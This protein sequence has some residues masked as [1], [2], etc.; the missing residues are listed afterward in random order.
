[1]VF[2]E[3]FN[4]FIQNKLNLPAATVQLYNGRTIAYKGNLIKQAN[5][6]QN[7]IFYYQST[8]DLMQQ[9]ASQLRLSESTFR[10]SLL[11]NEALSTFLLPYYKLDC[12]SNETEQ[13]YA[14]RIFLQHAH[15]QNIFHCDPEAFN[16]ILHQAKSDFF[17]ISMS[18]E[19]KEKR[20]DW[21]LSAY[22]MLFAGLLKH[23]NMQCVSVNV[24]KLSR[25]I[26]IPD[27]SFVKHH[28]FDIICYTGDYGKR[29]ATADECKFAFIRT[30]NE[31][32]AMLT[33]SYVVDVRVYSDELPPR[34]YSKAKL[35]VN[36]TELLFEDNDGKFQ[37]VEYQTLT[38]VKMIRSKLMAVEMELRDKTVL[39]ITFLADTRQACE[40]CLALLDLNYRCR[41]NS[42]MLIEPASPNHFDPF[43]V[44]FNELNQS[45][46]STN[47]YN[48]I[49]KSSLPLG[50][51]S[52]KQAHGILRQL[53][54][55]VGWYVFFRCQRIPHLHPLC[56]VL[57]SEANGD[58]KLHRICILNRDGYFYINN[59]IS[60]KRKG[61]ESPPN[62]ANH[63]YRSIQE[64]LYSIK[65]RVCNKKLLIKPEQLVTEEMIVDLRKNMVEFENDLHK[66]GHMLSPLCLHLVPM[67][68]SRRTLSSVYT[69]Y[70]EDPQGERKDVRALLYNKIHLDKEQL[71]NI[72]RISEISRPEF[73]H[74]NILKCFGFADSFNTIYY[75]HEYFGDEILNTFHYSY[76]S[77][78][79]Y[80]LGTQLK[81]ALQ[82]LHDKDIVHGFPALNNVYISKSRKHVKLGQ[83]GVLSAMMQ[84]SDVKKT[85]D[86]SSSN[87]AFLKSTKFPGLNEFLSGWFS[88]RRIRMLH[89]YPE[90]KLQE[91]WDRYVITIVYTG[92]A[93]K[94][95]TFAYNQVYL[96]IQFQ[97][98]IN[99]TNSPFSILSVSKS[100]DI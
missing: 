77:E 5:N 37:T 73:I 78:Q 64:L 83:I 62:E 56:I 1:M 68:L 36:M 27:R 6:G 82:F 92:W 54:L 48:I 94:Q 47:L 23:M 61:N 4:R 39:T 25:L 81:N 12:I 26:E 67:S 63:R 20:L 15:L 84:G 30:V 100:P 46:T 66:L 57:N 85:D 8:F 79:L 28:L 91:T 71:L 96:Q 43:S 75:V 41:V 29:Y 49:S 34:L 40:S 14:Y 90:E 44:S 38:K 97:K 99:F 9:C 69:G 19:F 87:S 72:A 13:H 89:E 58:K 2:L 16:Y 18:L 24:E 50:L 55:K 33:Y 7:Q 60:K 70:W 35:S 3:E 32:F 74:E 10:Y 93:I 76:S 88:Q 52:E 42:K 17:N 31:M 53:G 80:D 45:Q 11:T 59:E 95:C 86:A 51:L 21:V 98:T 22:G 65:I